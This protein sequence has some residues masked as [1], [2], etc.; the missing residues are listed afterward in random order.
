[1]SPF[2][3]CIYLQVYYTFSLFF[4]LENA[5]YWQYHAFYCVPVY[6]GVLFASMEAIGGE[7][8]ECM[9]LKI[10]SATPLS[11]AGSLMLDV[12]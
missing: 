7:Y 5:E 11:F 3:K 8:E 10:Q 4:V 1:M 2:I 12:T 6:F 9:I